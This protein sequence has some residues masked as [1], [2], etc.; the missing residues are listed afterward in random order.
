M[1]YEDIRYEVAGGRATITIDRP[2]RLNAFRGQTMLEL[3][4][5]FEAAADDESVGVIVFTGA[6]DRA[7][8]VGGDVQEPT[9]TMKEKRAGHIIGPRLAAAM[10]NNGKPIIC[11]VRGWCIGGGNELNMVSDLTIT[12]TTGRFGQA[13]PKIGSAPLWW[14]C[15]LIPAR[16]RRA[17]C[18]SS[19]AGTPHRR[20][21]RWAW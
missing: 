21:W 6:G 10:R 20:P 13:G 18:C 8:C 11:R 16:R 15:Q 14:G 4:E 1:S 19:P 12:D 9:R 17:R 7:F 3:C 5:A 2:D